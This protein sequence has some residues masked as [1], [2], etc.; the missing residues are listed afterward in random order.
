MTPYIERQRVWGHDLDFWVAD[1]RCASWYGVGDAG[2]RAD[3]DRPLKNFV[4]Y[5]MSVL[6]IGANVGHT[7]T[8]LAKAVGPWGRVVAVEPDQDNLVLLR[9][10]VR[11]NNL[12]HVEV[13]EAA[14]SRFPGA[15][16]LAG[17]M[18]TDPTRGDTRSVRGD[19]LGDFDVIKIDVEGFELPVVQ[20][21]DGLFRHRPLWEVE[22]HLEPDGGVSMLRYGHNPHELFE[23]FWQHAY[24]LYTRQREPE[25]LQP[26]YFEARPDRSCYLVAIPNEH[27][28]YPHAY[29]C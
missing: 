6:D 9:H 2:Y 14:A 10:N 13:V 11:L 21:C 7:T 15:V 27:P 29:L 20:G 8:V 25:P 24:R 23:L 17:E 4:A 18:V 22:L 19:S 3:W 16:Q 28:R 12:K 5:G 1:E 26:V